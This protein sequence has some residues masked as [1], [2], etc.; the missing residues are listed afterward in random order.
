MEAP[1]PWLSPPFRVCAASVAPL[2]SD[3]RCWS[4][5]AQ[6]GGA[7]SWPGA[8]GEAA[9]ACAAVT[10]LRVAALRDPARNES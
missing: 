2:L 4:E 7:A 1:A 9:G 8:G 6:S 10:P 3:W 5:R